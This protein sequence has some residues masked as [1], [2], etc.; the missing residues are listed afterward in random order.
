MPVAAPVTSAAR[1]S[2]LIGR[3]FSVDSAAPPRRLAGRANAKLRWYLVRPRRSTRLAPAAGVDVMSDRRRALDSSGG[4][5]M[6]PQ[7]LVLYETREHV[8]RITL[9][10]PEKLN[11][12]SPALA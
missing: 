4:S 7:G 2:P 12:L 3:P 10:R 9:N 1:R 5:R 11:A 8:A 6:E